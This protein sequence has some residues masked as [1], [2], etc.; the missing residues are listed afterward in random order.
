[1][2]SMGPR[3]VSHFPSVIAVQVA[4][5]P[6]LA[7]SRIA[8]LQV[9]L[10]LN[11]FLLF[12]AEFVRHLSRSI[13]IKHGSLLVRDITYPSMHHL[14]PRPKVTVGGLCPWMRDAFGWPVPNHCFRLTRS[15]NRERAVRTLPTAEDEC[16]CAEIAQLLLEGRKEEQLAET[17]RN[18]DRL[19]S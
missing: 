2:I 7:C 13:E 12:R 16:R 17:V 15:K 1:M 8:G 18:F 3:Y 11:S 5:G 14:L 4:P 19:S 6:R 9:S 10:G